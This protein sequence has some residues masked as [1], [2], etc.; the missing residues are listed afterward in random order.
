MIA[1]RPTTIED[2]TCG[3]LHRF[4]YFSVAGR[5][6]DASIF[7]SWYLIERSLIDCQSQAIKI[8]FRPDP[9]TRIGFGLSLAK[10]LRS[11]QYT[12]QRL[13]VAT[14]YRYPLAYPSCSSQ[15]NDRLVARHLDQRGQPLQY[16]KIST[17]RLGTAPVA[18]SSAG[19]STSSASCC[20]CSFDRAP[21]DEQV[22]P[23]L[24]ECNSI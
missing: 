9:G 18:G 7:D 19:S 16:S 3:K 12:H 5:N 22:T 24:R 2:M 11:L 23:R 15:Q 17:Q 14:I 8:T 4:R 1:A 13:P 6:A 20:S 10:M 21:R